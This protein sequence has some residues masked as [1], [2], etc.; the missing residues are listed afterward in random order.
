MDWAKQL[1]EEL[2]DATTLV[3]KMQNALS[4]GGGVLT[5]EIAA[6]SK[7][8]HYR[9][10]VIEGHVARWE[11]AVP[12]T[13]DQARTVLRKSMPLYVRTA[14][15]TTALLSKLPEKE[16]DQWV[17]LWMAEQEKG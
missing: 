2:A 3:W 11:L 15:G 14:D 8:L 4:E 13:R 9:T 16:F 12:L 6:Y 7:S 1:H 5:P 17:D 10:G